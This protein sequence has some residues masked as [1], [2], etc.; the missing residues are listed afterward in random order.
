MHMFSF[1]KKYLYHLKWHILILPPMGVLSW[2]GSRAYVV[3]TK[4]ENQIAWV[5]YIYEHPYR[6]GLALAATYITYRVI[7]K[8]AYALI[9]Q[10]QYAAMLEGIGLRKFSPHCD[11][12]DKKKDWDNCV[13]EIS[14]SAP[15]SLHILGATGWRTFGSPQSPLHDLLISFQGVIRILLIKPGSDGFKR[16]TVDLKHHEEEYKRE[17]LNTIEFCKELKEKHHKNIEVRL[18]TEEPIWKMILTEQYLW[19]QYYDPSSPVEDTPV[20]TLQTREPP[21]LSSLYYP[22]TR[23]FEKRWTEKTTKRVNLDTWNRN[24]MS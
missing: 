16:R 4:P 11:Q 10:K 3:A 12:A 22:L 24:N 8:V 15:H 13:K 6:I 21:T 1:F 23:V 18:Y 17:I 9:L 2:I 5:I 19:L 20:Y 14:S 7:N